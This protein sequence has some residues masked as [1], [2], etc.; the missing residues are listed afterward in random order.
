MNFEQARAN[1]VEQQIRPWDVL[2]QR[3]LDIITEV[4]REHFVSD[5]YLGV[6]YADSNIP[7]GHGESMM[8]PKLEARMIQALNIENDEHVL[9]VGTGS[10][11]VAALM[12]RLARRVTS[13]EIYPAFLQTA[14]KRLQ[15]HGYTNVECLEGDGCRGWAEN[16]P[17]DVIAL[18]GSLASLDPIFESQLSIGGRLFA[19]IGDSPIMNAEL[20]T[21]TDENTYTRETLFETDLKPLVGAE[22]VKAFNF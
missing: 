21:R 18:T 13:V 4:P 15:K 9:E 12:S 16:A 5:E 22:A 8:A 11:Y 2:D 20:I 7:L 10:G 14:E 6:A 3:V 1:M 19:V 17:Y